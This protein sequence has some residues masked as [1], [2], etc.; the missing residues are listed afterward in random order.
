MKK[1]WN[2]NFILLS[3][4]GFFLFVDQIIKYLSLNTFTNQHIY[5][6]LGWYPF[7]NPGIAFGISIPLL[8]IIFLS[9]IIIILIYIIWKKENQIA[10]KLGLALVLSGAI[11]NLIDRL[12]YSH[13]IDY[14]AFFTGIINLADTLIVI[15]FIIYLFSK[16]NKE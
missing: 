16:K 6:G 3:L 12:I 2:K 13:T 7:K 11:S 5:R 14:F 1:I 4:G 8:L 9:L 10:S 15:G